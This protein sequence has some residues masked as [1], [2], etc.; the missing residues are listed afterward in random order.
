MIAR[1]K[2]DTLE[3]RARHAEAAR[4]IRIDPGPRGPDVSDLEMLQRIEDALDRIDS[5]EYGYCRR[6]GEQI[7]VKALDSDPTLTACRS[8]RADG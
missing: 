7:P 1:L 6:C 5:G 2:E 3:L 4:P 8:C